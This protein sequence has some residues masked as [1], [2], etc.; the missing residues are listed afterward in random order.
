MYMTYMHIFEGMYMYIYTGIFSHRYRNKW[1][2]VQHTRIN[3]IYLPVCTHIHV[4]MHTLIHIYSY[5]HMYICILINSA[6]FSASS[7][8]DPAALRSLW[9]S[10]HSSRATP[11]T[12]ERAAECARNIY[13][14]IYEYNTWV[15][16]GIGIYI[17]IHIYI[18]VHKYTEIASG[19]VT[20]I[21]YVYIF[22]YVYICKYINYA[23]NFPPHS[24]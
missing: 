7:V 16:V 22:V 6:Y 8:C 4:C 5:M 21:L 20:Y 1:Q 24:L 2:G 18:Y 11:R 12:A 9:P 13:G 15:Y 23:F 17:V 3:S 10:S 19:T 14:C